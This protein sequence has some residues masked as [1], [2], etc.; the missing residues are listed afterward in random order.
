MPKYVYKCK[1]CDSYFEIVHGMN[2]THN[3]CLECGDRDNLIKVP[4]MPF[5]HK[6]L[7]TKA[8]SK[9]CKIVKEHIEQAKK[10]VSEQKR[11][12]KEDYKP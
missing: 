6:Q 5:V 11:K 2:E 10:E 8:N 4:Q 7:R 1:K 3:L 9:P 12:L